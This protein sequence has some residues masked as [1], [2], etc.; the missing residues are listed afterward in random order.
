MR[1]CHCRDEVI[2]KVRFRCCFNSL[3][4]VHGLLNSATG[5]VIKKR[6]ARSNTRRVTRR[7]H[8]IKRA[9]RNQSEHHG[10]FDTDVTAEGAGETDTIDC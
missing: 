4:T 7:R 1:K 3:G 6:Y 2:L 5:L 10:V 8:M 9:V